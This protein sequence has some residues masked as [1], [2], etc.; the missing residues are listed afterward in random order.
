[1][2]TDDVIIFMCSESLNMERL[3][4]LFPLVK[5]ITSSRIRFVLNITVGDGNV[6]VLFI[7][8]ACYVHFGITPEATT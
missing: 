5:K 8:I 6:S 4:K 3:L 2:N 7:M 1:M